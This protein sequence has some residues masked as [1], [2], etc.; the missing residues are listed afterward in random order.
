MLK[1]FLIIGYAAIVILAVA[2]VA[3]VSLRMSDSAIK[4]KVSSLVSSL[5]VQMGLNMESY[6]DRMET[7]ATLA[8]ASEE[9]YKYD[10]NTIISLLNTNGFPQNFSF[11]E[12][13]NI[14][15]IIKADI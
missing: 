12:E 13:N 1:Y 2:A 15:P 3:T 5:N 7:I 9:T 6:L 10:Y 4:N 8:F 11:L 14:S